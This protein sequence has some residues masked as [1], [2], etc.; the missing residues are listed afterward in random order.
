MIFSSFRQSYED[1]KSVK[2]QPPDLIHNHNTYSEQNIQFPDSTGR[3]NFGGH[4]NLTL[5]LS[6]DDNKNKSVYIHG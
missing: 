6:I 1:R 4:G 5:N 2:H 3:R